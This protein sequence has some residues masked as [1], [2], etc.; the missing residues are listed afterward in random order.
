MVLRTEHTPSLVYQ[1]ALAVVLSSGA[2]GC[3]DSKQALPGDDVVLARVEEQPVTRFDLERGVDKS[4]GKFAVESVER[5]ARGQVLESLLQSKAMAI[6]GER[7][8][9]GAQRKLIEKE[10]SAFRENLL[11]K[12]YLAK[13]SPFKDVTPQE[14]RKYYDDHPSRYGAKTDRRYELIFGKNAAAGPQRV[15]LMTRLTELAEQ[16]NWS[17]PAAESA[18]DLPL[19]YAV[20]RLSE[21]S[22]HPKLKELLAGLKVGKASNIVFVQGRPYLAR[23]V[24]EDQLPP[25][26]FEEVKSDIESTLTTLKLRD[27]VRNVG[28]KALERVK[29]ERTA[30]ASSDPKGDKNDG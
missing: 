19:G 2:F 24:A 15:Q 28:K 10:V 9:T 21:K 18:L 20:G 5:N 23:I 30:E 12:A 6:L 11:V 22:L 16:A 3:E 13:E 4:L 25:R 14:V 8:L 29:V 1:A 7:E 27:A 26:P 17:T